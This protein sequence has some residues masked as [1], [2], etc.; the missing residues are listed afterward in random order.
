MNESTRMHPSFQMNAE[1]AEHNATP[2]RGIKGVSVLL[3][4]AFFKLPTGVVVNY[5][6]AVCSEFVKYTTGTWFDCKLAFPFSIEGK[7][8]LSR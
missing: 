4:L 8:S 2:C 6:D 3:L 1:R 7:I 5:M